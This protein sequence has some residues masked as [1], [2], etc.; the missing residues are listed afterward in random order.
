MLVINQVRHERQQKEL[1]VAP[2]VIYQAEDGRYCLSNGVEHRF[3]QSTFAPW[4]MEI[5][6]DSSNLA[7]MVSDFGELFQAWHFTVGSWLYRGFVLLGSCLAFGGC[8]GF[9]LPLVFGSFGSC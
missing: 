7:F 6:W 4:V 8:G 5:K 9:E 1:T 2:L 3:L